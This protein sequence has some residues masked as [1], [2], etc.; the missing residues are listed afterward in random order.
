MLSG[1]DL[2]L[3]LV[4]FGAGGII[5][6]AVGAGAPL[7]AIPVMVMLRDAPFA[8]AVFVLPNIVPN[9]VQAWQYRAALS[10]PRFA[11]LFALGG[12]I[13]AAAGT[14]ALARVSSER[15]TLVVAVL[16]LIYVG[17]RIIRPRMVMPEPLALRLAAPVG[18]I[19]GGLQ[20]AT[21]LS[22]PVSLGFMSLTGFARP[23]FAATISLFFIALG[24][25]QLPAQLAL[26]VM[27]GER[28][29]YSALALIPL[30]AGM[31][32]G[33]WLGARLS[34]RAF[35]R[36][37]LGLLFALAVRLIWGVL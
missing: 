8:V 18:L 16:L 34:A 36:V 17:L 29:L 13:G 20:G 14:L 12:G 21:G 2:A 19:A 3:I 26:G 15:L 37:V 27:T 33:A 30:F 9:L 10:A 32:I 22:A 7:L 4:A 5:K 24:L 25:A 35:D 11:L 1:P 31:P 28:L 6:G 23:T